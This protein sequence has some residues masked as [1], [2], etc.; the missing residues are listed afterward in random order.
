MNKRLS[1]FNLLELGYLLTHRSVRSGHVKTRM[2]A[3][4]DMAK[5][6]ARMCHCELLEVRSM[7]KESRKL[8]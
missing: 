7:Q 3:V 6:K 4:K 5:E 2:N 1:R 8:Q